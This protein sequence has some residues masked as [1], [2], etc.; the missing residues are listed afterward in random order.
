MEKLSLKRIAAALLA[1]LI[2]AA[3]PLSA[4]AATD[5]KAPYAAVLDRLAST[6]PS[7]GSVGGEWQ[8]IAVVRGGKKSPSSDWCQRYYS[9][10]ESMVRANGSGVVSPNKSTDNSRLVLALTAIGRNA[11]SVADF[12]L[13]AP[14]CDINYTKKQGVTGAA[15]ALLALGCNSAYG[16]SAAK[17][18]LVDFLLAREKDGGGWSL[19]TEPDTD[20]TAMVITALA[21]YSK[22]SAAVSR[23]VEKLSQLQNGDGSFSSLGSVNCESSA[24]VVVALST[25]GINADTDPRFIKGGVSALAAL[26]SYYNDGGFSHTPGGSVNG[27]ATEQSAYALCAY[28]RFKN[29][30]RD[31][32]DMNDVSFVSEPTPKPTATPK[33]TPAPTAAPKPTAA[34]TAAPKPTAAPTET[35]K[36]TAVPTNTAPPT[37]APTEPPAPTEAPTELPTEAPTSE[38]TVLPTETPAVTDEPVSEGP[39]SESPAASAPTASQTEPAA[40]NGPSDERAGERGFPGALAVAIVAV[41]AVAAGAAVIFLGRK[42]K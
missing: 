36:P 21:P 18:E 9:S 6:N 14:L 28:D 30:R 10:I 7:F 26:L 5:Y 31:L 25:V 33:P 42:R 34:P 41:C 1:M 32:F 29:G 27:M 15:F 23:G 13:V 12:D 40:S 24:Q 16:E 22:A 3:A 8:V 4:F 17:N 20:A 38:P 37:N 2:M 39:A 35:P 11:R 19:G